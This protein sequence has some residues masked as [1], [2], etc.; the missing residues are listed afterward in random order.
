[1][2]R[3]RYVRQRDEYSCGPVA[4]MNLAKWAGVRAPYS[5]IGRYRRMC[6]CDETGSSPEAFLDAI[7]RVRGIEV[8]ECWYCADGRMRGLWGMLGDVVPRPVGV[9]DID[10][11]LDAGNAMVLVFRHNRCGKKDEDTEHAVLITG[12]TPK[13]YVAHNLEPERGRTTS[14][15]PRRRMLRKLWPTSRIYFARKKRG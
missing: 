1:M 15:W 6:E 7:R 5:E 11:W 4:V 2:G 13:S 8:E 10:S 9:G 12:R 14:R 3:P